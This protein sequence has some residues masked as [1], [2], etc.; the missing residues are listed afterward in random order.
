MNK[1]LNVDDTCIKIGRGPGTYKHAGNIRFRAMIE[2][3][4][5]TYQASSKQMKTFIVNTVRQEMADSGMKF[6]ELNERDQTWKEVD[7]AAEVRKKVAH[8]F[9]DAVEAEKRKIV[10]NRRR[11]WS[12]QRQKRSGATTPSL[13]SDS[14]DGSVSTA[15]TAEPIRSPD[16]PPWDRA[17]GKQ[18]SA[19]VELLQAQDI[20]DYT[21]IYNGI[22]RE[23]TLSEYEIDPIDIRSCNFSYHPSDAEGVYPN[24]YE[25]MD[26]ESTVLDARNYTDTTAHHIDAQAHNEQLQRLADGDLQYDNHDAGLSMRI[27]AGATEVIKQELSEIFDEVEELI[28]STVKCSKDE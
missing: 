15:D 18:K 19:D 1:I 8:R 5:D 12:Q 23:V 11:K 3:H 6:V 16:T 2:N 10:A 27:M 21:N 28:G 7:N 26:F 14:S 25:I 9:R 22:P 4:L 24:G 17:I 20:A 13:C